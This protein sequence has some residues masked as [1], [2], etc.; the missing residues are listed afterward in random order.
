MQ[1]SDD[2]AYLQDVYVSTS[3]V[4][5]AGSYNNWTKVAMNKDSVRP[6]EW[7]ISLKLSPGVHE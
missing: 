4:E 1:W 7:S 3:L 6:G 2:I 5:V